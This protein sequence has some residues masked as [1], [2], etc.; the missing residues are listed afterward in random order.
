MRVC[1]RDFF[2]Y[3]REVSKFCYNIYSGC[4]ITIYSSNLQQQYSGVVCPLYQCN[5]VLVRMKWKE[6][7]RLN[8]DVQLPNSFSRMLT[9]SISFFKSC[10]LFTG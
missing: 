7:E 4:G 10:M 6:S 2:E 9:F 5:F 8:K 3:N 1:F